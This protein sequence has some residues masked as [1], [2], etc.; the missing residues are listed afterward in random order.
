[1]DS[2]KSKMQTTNWIGLRILTRSISVLILHLNILVLP[3]TPLN[4]SFSIFQIETMKNYSNELHII[5]LTYWDCSVHFTNYL[6]IL[7]LH[8]PPS[9]K[10][11]K[12]FEC[13]TMGSHMLNMFLHMKIQSNHLAYYH[14]S[15]WAIKVWFLNAGYQ[16]SAI[17]TIIPLRHQHIFAWFI[18]TARLVSHIMCYCDTKNVI[19][20]WR[21]YKNLFIEYAP[22][23]KQHLSKN[24]CSKQDRKKYRIKGRVHPLRTILTWCHMLNLDSHIQ[25]KKK[26][27]T[28]KWMT[29]EPYW[30]HLKNVLWG[31]LFSHV[32]V[33]YFLEK[34]FQ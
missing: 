1:M 9:F 12:Y 30:K 13:H 8:L 10:G 28:I 34:D 17:M 16:Q 23:M 19:K 7:S 29:Q 15:I 11:A 21:I 4:L 26:M 14:I 22:G 32:M 31:L 27:I 3:R 5:I 20:V 2:L 6:Q 33:K 24:K 18:A 25:L